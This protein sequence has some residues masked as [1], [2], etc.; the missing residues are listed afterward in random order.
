MHCSPV[1]FRL[2]P[3]RMSL[4]VFAISVYTYVRVMSA[5]FLTTD[6]IHKRMCALGHDIRPDCY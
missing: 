3:L 6:E 4:M 2:A 1:V 5:S